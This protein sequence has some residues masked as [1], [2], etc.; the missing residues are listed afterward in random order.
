MSIIQT[1]IPIIAGILAIIYRRKVSLFIQKAYEKFPK[2][3]DGVKAFNINFSVR[4][5]FITIL[6]VI[7]ILISLMSFIG[8]MELN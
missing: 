3:E 2:Y 4:P 5:G 8:Q 7:W 1:I 6:A